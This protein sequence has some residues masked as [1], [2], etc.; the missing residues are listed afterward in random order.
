M[1]IFTVP[2]GIDYDDWVNDTDDGNWKEVCRTCNKKLY[3][4][5]SL[6]HDRSMDW[7]FCSTDC[8]MKEMGETDEDALDGYDADETTLVDIAIDEWHT[9]HYG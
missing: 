3:P 7:L 4:N 8:F 9:Q 1:G 2:E 6:I 5:D